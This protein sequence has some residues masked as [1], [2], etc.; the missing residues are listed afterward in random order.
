MASA[1]GASL[2][3]SGFNSR[4]A[5]TKTKAQAAMNP[6]AKRRDNKPAGKWRDLVRGLRASISASSTRLNAM[7]TERAATMATTIQPMRQARAARA[8]PAS[9]QASSAPVSAKGSAKTLCSNLI[10]SSVNRRRLR[11][12]PNLV[13]ILRNA[14]DSHG[15][16]GGDAGGVRRARIHHG[17][18]QQHR[19]HARQRNQTGVPDDEGRHRSDARA[20]VS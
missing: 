7:A 4:A 5:K 16:G 15:D 11:N 6:Q 1:S 8:K 13:T 18:H 20:D 3:H 2:K 9:R 17:G 19:R 14:N 10:I 12:F